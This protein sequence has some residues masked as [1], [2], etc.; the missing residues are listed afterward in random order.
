MLYSS[1]SKNPYFLNPQKCPHKTTVFWG[2][3]TLEIS[4]HHYT[5]PIFFEKYPRNAI[6]AENN[7]IDELYLI[8][9]S[10]LRYFLVNMTKNK[11]I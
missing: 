7:Q 6:K 3:S 8:F 9:T 10:N 11:L 1:T 5:K 4:N 2:E